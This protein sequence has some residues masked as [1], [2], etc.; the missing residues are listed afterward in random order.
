MTQQPYTTFEN[1]RK[2]TIYHLGKTDYSSSDSIRDEMIN[3]AISEIYNRWPFMWSRASETL[4]MSSNAS[5][6]DSSFNNVHPI[7]KVEDSNENLYTRINPR[8]K[9]Q[10]DSLYIYWIDFDSSNNQWNLNIPSDNTETTIE[11]IYH[12][13]P[14]ELSDATD[15]CYIP[16]SSAVSYL[17]AAK[18]WLAKERD[19]SNFKNL[20]MIAEQKIQRM[21]IQDKRANEDTRVKTLTERYNLGFTTREL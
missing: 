17:A 14:E 16:D 9:N 20:M 8:D 11:T 13:L 19:E 15:K 10:T 2:Q 7:I 4:T 6:L 5:L 1:L 3:E 18:Y 12:I 21:I